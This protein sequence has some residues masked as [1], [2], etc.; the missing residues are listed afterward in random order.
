MRPRHALERSEPSRPAT[1]SRR[2][3][4]HRGGARRGDDKAPA[5]LAEEVHPGSVVCALRDA[6]FVDRAGRHGAGRIAPPFIAAQKSLPREKGGGLA[7]GAAGTLRGKAKGK[8]PSE[9]GGSVF[10]PPDKSTPT[11][12]EMGIDKHLADSAGEILAA[13]AKS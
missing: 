1:A 12:A 2:A 9:S 10:V 5:R 7:R 3:F 6:G 13:V 4:P 8:K 11:L